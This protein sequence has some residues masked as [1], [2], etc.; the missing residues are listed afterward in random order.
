MASLLGRDRVV[1]Q[2]LCD[3]GGN[4]GDATFRGGE[5]DLSVLHHEVDALDDVRGRRWLR[6][7]LLRAETQQTEEVGEGGEGGLGRLGVLDG[8]EVVD[9]VSTGDEQHG[10]QQELQGISRPIEMPHGRRCAETH[11]V[12]EPQ[13]YTACGREEGA[14]VRRFPDRPLTIC[15]EQVVAEDEHL[16]TIRHKAECN[17][18]EIADIMMRWSIGRRHRGVVVR[19]APV[20]AAAKFQ[21]AVLVRLGDERATKVSPGGGSTR[22]LAPF[23]KARRRSWWSKSSAIWPGR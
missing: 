18:G 20:L 14:A 2:R 13:G 22:R 21:V 6:L 7:R 11:V 16:A 17:V 12:V 8:I 4:P 10:A 5:D 1:L 23:T 19:A 9:V 15:V 3:V